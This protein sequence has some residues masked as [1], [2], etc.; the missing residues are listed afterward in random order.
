MVIFY[1]QSIFASWLYTYHMSEILH[2]NIFFLITSIAVIVVTILVSIGLYY[3]IC[4]LRAVRDIAERVREGS[5]IIAEDAAQLREDILSGN[6]FSALFA[7]AAMMTGFAG[8]RHTRTKKS[9]K[10]NKE[11]MSHEVENET[12]IDIQ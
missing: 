10:N 12:K 11:K 4:I 2:S 3:V 9:E 7:K 5:E 6:I 8:R 1:T